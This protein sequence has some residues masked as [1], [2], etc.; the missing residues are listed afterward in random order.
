MVDRPP[1]LRYEA[2]SPC[3]PWSSDG[4][5]ATLQ[6]MVNWVIT[7]V[8]SSGAV[9]ASI[10]PTT[11]RPEPRAVFGHLEIQDVG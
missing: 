1:Y 5:E 2:G 9:T 11:V 10:S 4:K 8:V 7:S 3:G 6:A